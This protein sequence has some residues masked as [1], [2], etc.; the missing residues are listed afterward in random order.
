MASSQHAHPSPRPLT[1]A[2]VLSAGKRKTVLI[3]VVLA[4]ATL[5][6]YWPTLGN[7]F[8]NYDDNEYV[9]E[10]QH[11]LGGLSPRN[12]RWAFVAKSASNWH[13]LTW[14]S[15]M[16]DVTQFGTGPTGPHAVNLLLHTINGALLFLLLQRMTGAQLRS[17]FVAGLF[18]LHPLHVESVAWVAERKDVLSTM[19]W[20]LTL[21]AYQAYVKSA[22]GKKWYALALLS[23]ALGLM[24]KPMLVT[25]PLVMLLL[26]FWPL[27]RMAITGRSPPKP[28]IPGL[29]V[30]KVPFLLLSALSSAVTCWAQKSAMPSLEHLP[31]SERMAN[32]AVSYVRYLGK[33]FWPQDLALPYLHPGQWSEAQVWL[34]AVLI[35]ALS[36]GAVWTGRKHPYVV[37]GWFWYL[38]TLVPV[39]GL[40]QVGVQAIADRYTYVPLTGVFIIVAWAAG[41]LTARRR[42]LRYG[43]VS[44]G[45]LILAICGAVTHRQVKYWHDSETLFKHAASVTDGNFVAL[46]NV[47]GA[48]FAK[49]RN[50]EALKYYREAVRINPN[51]TEALNS[52]GA[53]LAD[54]G[55]PEAAEWFQR[56]LTVQP[57]HADTLFNMGN[58][59]AKEGK[60]REAAEYYQASLAS[61]PD[62]HEARNNLAGVMVRMG[63]I[64]EAIAQYQTAL[65]IKPDGALVHKNLGEMLAA[66]GKLDEAIAHYRTALTLTNDA[67]AHYSL[68][69]TLAVQGRWA[70][71][72]EQY[73]RTLQLWPT[74]TDA[75]YNLGYAL[76]MTGQLE[77][78]RTNLVEALRLKPNF[79]M[80]E[81]NLGCVLADQNRTAEA[82][83]HLQEALRL[84]PDYAEARAKL[85]TLENQ[86]ETAPK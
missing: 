54:K 77:P 47:G 22:Q 82:V 80:A 15:H 68:G 34:A 62:N 37:T 16:L 5:A 21:L 11:V 76:R 29:V 70:E 45:I 40:V 67:G 32:A 72:I 30:E 33:M 66:K 31:V 2:E 26:D 65:E 60:Y 13:P 20:M 52:I 55:D 3:I 14:L 36:L 63:R 1:P 83:T 7:G 86:G 57:A 75:R 69:M 78:A 53:V 73:N 8:I 64:D 48:Y 27:R 46:S 58:L 61:R 28:T 49:G 81:F 42:S 43:A 35:A 71:A 10:N 74:N 44:M 23:Y 51:Y 17:A 12:V 84:K 4:A 38:G 6:T 19:F 9:T 56:A 18:A 79:P 59:M 85:R 24:S 39:I 50:D 41:E 25:I